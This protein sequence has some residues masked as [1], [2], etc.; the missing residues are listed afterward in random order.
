M[1]PIGQ[2]NPS[3]ILSPENIE[4]IILEGLSTLPLTGMKVLVIIP[5]GTRTIPIPLFFRLLTRHLQGKV[6]ALDFIVALGTHAPL[7]EGALL[8]HVGITSQEKAAQYKDVHLINHTW[9]DSQSLVNLGKI[10]AE[11]VAALSNNLMKME[12]PV[13]INR[14]ILDYDHLLICGPVFPHEIVGFSGGNKYFFPGI[15]GPEIID[16]THWLGALITSY[17]NIGIKD[18]PVRRAID[19]AASLIPIPRHAFCSV[20]TH[21]GVFGLFFGTPEEAFSA[22]A[23]LSSQIHIHWQEKP[24]QKVLA[25]LAPL[26]PEIWTGSKGMY[27]AEPVVAEG[28][29]IILYA[30]H[31]K[32]ISF[33]HG[34]ILHKIGYHVRD[35]YLA[36]WDRYS[37]YPWSVLSHSTFLRGVGTYENGVER[38]RIQVTLATGI[39]AD[40]CQQVNLGYCDPAKI[41]PKSWADR[42]GEGILL[43]PRAGEYLY[44]LK[45]ASTLPT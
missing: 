15:A 37:H 11:E 32:E 29:E 19:R 7:D 41:D 31:I 35:Y 3:Y 24:F 16:I 28:G 38:P 1:K 12:M 39:P 45:P 6:K 25:V 20:V 2:G 14:R 4:A 22:A 43:I 13:R 33:T 23:D 30:P 40:L 21:E 42:E 8:R 17:A 18:N 27:K 10:D 9:Q 26:Y 34:A 5:D 44:R 36:H